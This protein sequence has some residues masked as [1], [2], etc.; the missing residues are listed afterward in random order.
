MQKRQNEKIRALA[1]VLEVQKGGFFRCQLEDNP[2]HEVIA[3]LCGQMRKGRIIV[4]VGDLVTVD[5][6]PYDLTRG[7]IVWREK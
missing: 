1:I 2:T 5:L 3:Y 7:R 4:C 6:S